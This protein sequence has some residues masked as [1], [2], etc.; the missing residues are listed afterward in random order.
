MGKTIGCITTLK[1]ALDY[2]DAG[3]K[4]AKTSCPA[5]AVNYSQVYNQI[6]A[7]R[8]SYSET[9]KNAVTSAKGQLFRADQACDIV[10]GKIP[11]TSYAACASSGTGTGTGTGTGLQ[12]Q[13]SGS[14]GPSSDN[15][16]MWWLLLAGAVAGGAWWYADYSKKKKKGVK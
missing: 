5:A 4:D 16:W 1:E 7:L 8:L 2:A 13:T 15:S 9:D 3:A 6:V 10:K 12:N 14:P 11:A